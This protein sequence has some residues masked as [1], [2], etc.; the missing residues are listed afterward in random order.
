VS[1]GRLAILGSKG[2]PA[3]RAPDRMP[4]SALVEL[5]GR[6]VVVDCG[7][8]VT[9]GLVTAGVGLRDGLDVVLV[10]HLHSDHVLEL[11]PLLHTAW[12]TGTRRPVRV[13]GPPGIAEYWQGFLA[14]M[15]FDNRIRVEDEGRRP[16]EALVTVTEIAE[17]CVLDEDGLRIDALRVP[18][19]PVADCFAFRVR[20]GGGTVVFSGDTAFFPPLAEFARGADVLVHEALHPLGVDL[21]VERTGLGE[22]LRKHLLASH[23]PAPDAARLASRA[24]VGHLVLYHLVPADLP[25]VTEA[26]WAEAVDGIFAGPVTLARDGLEITIGADVAA[27][28]ERKGTAT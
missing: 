28:E 2:G 13:F 15:A 27:G 25:E 16:L 23:T 6:R 20:A 11:G 4:T 9:R 5:G 24:G 12:T 21:L 1:A 8:G 7:L 18:H 17:G 10:S 3:L 14:S 26:R 22:A 19:P